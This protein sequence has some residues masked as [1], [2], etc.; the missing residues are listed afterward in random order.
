MA[1]KGDD[2]WSNLRLESVLSQERSETNVGET[3]QLEVI[4]EVGSQWLL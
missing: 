1:L 3:I 4:D 2:C